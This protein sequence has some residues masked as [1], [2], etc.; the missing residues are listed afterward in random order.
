[1]AAPWPPPYPPATAA[2]YHPTTPTP[3]L[4]QRMRLERWIAQKAK[5][6]QTRD[7]P[8]SAFARAFSPRQVG[9]LVVDFNAAVRSG[10]AS[11]RPPPTANRRQHPASRP[12]PMTAR[13][14]TS[15]SSPRD[16]DDAFIQLAAENKIGKRPPPRMGAGGAPILTDAE[17]IALKEKKFNAWLK[18]YGAS[19]VRTH[20]QHAVH[21]VHMVHA[22]D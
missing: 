11:A 3:T 13:A 17:M 5:A 15:A 12:P 9:G 4:G 1:M 10:M 2:Q 21:G 22:P 14:S 18:R 20:M 7:D 19:V 6:D 8:S 16:G